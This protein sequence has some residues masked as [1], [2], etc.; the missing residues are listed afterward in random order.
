MGKR[1]ASTV[2][3]LV[4]YCT[5]CPRAANGRNRNHTPEHTASKT[6]SSKIP[7]TSQSMPTACPD[8]SWTASDFGCLRIEPEAST[9]F[10][11]SALCGPNAAL[12]C[13]S[14]AEKNAFVFSMATE[15]VAAG[16]NGGFTPRLAV[17][18][19]MRPEPTGNYIRRD[20]NWNICTT[21]NEAVPF[22]NWELGEPAYA[23]GADVDGRC[24]EMYV[25]GQWRAQR[26]DDLTYC[27]CEHGLVTSA[28][29]L[30]LR[31]AFIAH[32]NAW[33]GITYG[34]IIPSL[35]LLPFLIAHAC[36]ACRRWRLPTPSAAAAAAAATADSTAT[37][38]A[39]AEV[40][41]Q[42]LRSRI[43]NTVMLMAWTFIVVGNTPFTLWVMNIYLRRTTGAF[44]NYLGFFV[45]DWGSCHSLFARPMPP[46]L[47]LRAASSW[48][49]PASFCVA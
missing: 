2:P 34:V 1:G 14:S 30:A 32:I 28:E 9:P 27:V 3:V 16:F 43:S 38:L 41:S 31:Q 35:S 4:Y 18:N 40:A 37:K 8:S 26:C 13:I 45:S 11:C 12:A 25:A 24:V 15:L 20:E 44:S 19:Y 29:F 22:T 7:H 42:R 6:P 49:F 46:E 5:V 21:S 23:G 47:S 39:A 36:S 10:E 33:T 17:G 48:P